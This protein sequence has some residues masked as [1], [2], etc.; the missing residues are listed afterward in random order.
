MAINSIHVLMCPDNSSTDESYTVH[1]EKNG[2]GTFVVKP[3]QYAEKSEPG[4][5][6]RKELLP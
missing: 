2:S 5:A 6:Q 4:C 3:S 1:Q